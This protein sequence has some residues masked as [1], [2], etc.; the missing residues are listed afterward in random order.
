VQ[1]P[2]S[3]ATVRTRPCRRRRRIASLQTP[4]PIP[5]AIKLLV[6]IPILLLKMSNFWV[7]RAK[8][9][10]KEVFRV[11]VL[12]LMRQ[13]GFADPRKV[14]RQAMLFGHIAYFRALYKQPK[15]IWLPRACTDLNSLCYNSVTGQGQLLWVGVCLQQSFGHG[16]AW[17]PWCPL[18]SE[19]GSMGL[20]QAT[21]ANRL[22]LRKATKHAGFR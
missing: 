14:H 16:L 7:P 18:T 20:K 11:A 13:S 17:C 22:N 5:H 6:A 12:S 21:Q 15:A 10:R 1:E 8:G 4:R 9:G 3:D 19:F 2:D